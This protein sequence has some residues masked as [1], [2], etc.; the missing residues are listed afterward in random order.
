MGGLARQIP[1]MADRLPKP[2]VMDNQFF[3][4]GEECPV[5][6][7]FRSGDSTALA[8]IFHE[9]YDSLYF[10]GKKLVQDDDLVKDCVQNLF[11]KMWK[12]RHN[13]MAVKSVR[14]Y[15]LKSLRR[16]IGDQIT[17][18]NRQKTIQVQYQSEFQI[19]FSHEDFL[20][21][22]QTDQEQS[23]ALARCLNT[24]PSRQREALFLRFYEG[25]D[26][27]RIAEVMHLNVQS[28]R[29]LIHQSLKSIKRLMNLPPAFL[30]AID[31]ANRE[32]PSTHRSPR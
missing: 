17:A 4:L 16:H 31:N 10:Y 28:V 32:S 21:A 27:P 26:Y 12:T 13:L 23:E 7:H 5:W 24:L 14:P 11:L 19:T 29:N 8:T 15:L 22:S 30:S 25:L 6:R 1:F 18:L 3:F 2:R 9:N 20:I